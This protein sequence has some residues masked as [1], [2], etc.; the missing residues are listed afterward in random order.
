MLQTT[1][2]EDQR[3]VLIGR[4]ADAETAY[5]TLLLGGTARVYV[6]Q[7]GERVEFAPANASRLAAYIQ[8]LKMQLGLIGVSRPA[9][10]FIA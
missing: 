7:S 8:S 6:D 3:L 9:G 5:H 1:L 4:L 2:T 10:V